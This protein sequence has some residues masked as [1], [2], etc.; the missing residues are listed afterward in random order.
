M[1]PTG[2]LVEVADGIAA[3]IADTPG[4]G[5]SNLA[6]VIEDDG[7]TVVDSGTV[8]SHA[9][10]FAETLG[11][12]GIPIRRLVLTSSHVDYAGGSSAYP[13]AAVY[14]SPQTSA[15]LD[16]PPNTA[17]Y[18]ALAP[19]LTD[20]FLDIVTR[21]VTHTVREAAWISGRV[22]VAPTGGQITENLVAQV[23]DANVVLAGAMA[24]FGVVPAAFGGDPARWAEQLDV[25][26]G[27]GAVVVPGHGPVG[28]AP[29]IGAL[30]AYLRACVDAAGDLSA[31]AEGPWQTWADQRF[32]ESNVERAAMLDA[33]D[34]SPPPSILTLMGLA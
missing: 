22:V 14:G 9:A 7:I 23:P 34:P 19:L 21:P 20:E 2:E 5:A 8:P 18:A 16:Q 28:G 12:L 6:A 1:T 17:A 26:L 33:G 32:H 25:V 15:H 3:W 30:Q 31:M 13:L 4:F 27:W 10:P 11:Q 29:E 24:S